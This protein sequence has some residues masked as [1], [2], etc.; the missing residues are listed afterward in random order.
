MRDT[1]LT[2]RT[3][4]RRG[5]LLA[6]AGLVGRPGGAL[7]AHYCGY[8]F[9]PI[10]Q[11]IYGWGVDPDW[12]HDIIWRESN[13]QPG[14][15]NPYSDAAGLAQFMPSTWRWGEERFGIWGSPY[16]WVTNL[17]MMNAFLREGEYYHWN[18]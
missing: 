7:A 2:R 1:R 18:L 8:Q 16:D 13:F 4:V 12:Q 5:L 3:L 6:G 9:G 15:T 14:A 10:H 17:Q 11:A